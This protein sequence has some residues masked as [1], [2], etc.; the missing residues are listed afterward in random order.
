MPGRK[1][2][3]QGT[4]LRL[5][6]SSIGLDFQPE[7]C[8]DDETIERYAA[9]LRAG[10]AV[11]PVVVNFD[12]EHYWLRDGFHRIKAA[13]KIGLEEIEAEVIRGTYEDMETEWRAGLEQ[14]KAA[15]ARWAA[16]RAKRERGGVR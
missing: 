4:I 8:L 1:G 9:V 7:E 12:G 3:E 2:A 10:G 15:T 6:I 5:P 14:A 13:L 16:A 11:L